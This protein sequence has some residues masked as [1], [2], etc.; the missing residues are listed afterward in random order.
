MVH[1]VHNT[2][3]INRAYTVFAEWTGINGMKCIY[4]LDNR[5]IGS[6]RCIFLRYFVV[7]GAE[8]YPAA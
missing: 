6:N 4:A 7:W 5:I 2:T 1:L 8:G 3:T